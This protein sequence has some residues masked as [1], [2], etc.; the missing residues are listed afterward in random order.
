MGKKNH[1]DKAENRILEQYFNSLELPRLLN[2][3]DLR[4]FDELA[5][6]YAENGPNF[7]VSKLRRLGIR[8]DLSENVGLAFHIPDDCYIC[9]NYG[10][11][12]DLEKTFSDYNMLRDRLL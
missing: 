5:R 3:L 1:Y 11:A 8:I 10:N 12:Y 4:S 7:P 9:L 6:Y 2:G